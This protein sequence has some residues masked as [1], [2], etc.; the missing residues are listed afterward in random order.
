MLSILAVTTPIYVIML[1]GFLAVRFGLF[2]TADMRVLGRL[3]IYFCLPALLFRT[4]AQQPLADIV[5]GVYLAA[6]AAGSLAALVLLV[7]FAA[8]VLRRP[9]PVAAMFGLGASSSNSGFVG[10]PIA[11]Q[12]LGPAAGAALALTMLV[13]NLLTIPLSLVLADSERGSIRKVLLDSVRNLARNPLVIAIVAGFLVALLQWPLP[14]PIAR[15]LQI[16]ATG[17]TPLALFVVGGSLVGLRLSGQRRDIAAVVVGKL[18]LH[19][20]AVFAALAVL[21]PL[22]ADL[23]TCAV[24]FAAMPMLSVYPVLA[25]RYGQEKFCAAVLLVTTAISFVTITGLLWLLRS[26]PGWH[27]QG[28]AVHAA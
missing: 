10:F 13:E 23:R 5:N 25:Q 1:G 19:P 4:V 11:L 15:T 8:G 3:V 20:L 28:L 6:Y 21:P 2:V 22:D 12:L 26:L 16:V 14:D 17:S 18:V 24:L 9:L 27:V 7:W